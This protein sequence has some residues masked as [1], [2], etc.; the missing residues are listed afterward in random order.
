MRGKRFPVLCVQTPIDR[1]R[2]CYASKVNIRVNIRIN[3]RVGGKEN[4]EDKDE[5]N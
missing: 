5:K 4:L 2:G 3:I 1:P